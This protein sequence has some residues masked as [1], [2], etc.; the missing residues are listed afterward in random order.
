MTIYEWKTL[1]QWEQEEYQYSI[2]D[3][4]AMNGTFDTCVALFKSGKAA[5][6]AA[7]RLNQTHNDPMGMPRY[8]VAENEELP[9]E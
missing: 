7:K 1:P 2:I 5:A 4:K 8:V 6:A 3:L 9:P